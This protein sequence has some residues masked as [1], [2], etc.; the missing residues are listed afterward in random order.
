MRV[1]SYRS[2]LPSLFTLACTCPFTFTCS[3][4]FT[5]ACNDLFTLTGSCLS[6]VLSSFCWFKG[7]VYPPIPTNSPNDE[8]FSVDNHF[9]SC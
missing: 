6:T 9:L 8:P 1:S 7:R 2:C 3:S 5:L 4:P